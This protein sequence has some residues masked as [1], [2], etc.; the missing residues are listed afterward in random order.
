MSALPPYCRLI[1]RATA[2]CRPGLRR[3]PV[4]PRRRVG[5]AGRLGVRPPHGL[6]LAT[7]S[8]PRRLRITLT[9]KGVQ[10]DTRAQCHMAHSAISRV[11]SR[12]EWIGPPQSGY[13]VPGYRRSEDSG[14][15]LPT[16]DEM[17]ELR[18]GEEGHHRAGDG[19]RRRSQVCGRV[20]R[21]LR[22]GGVAASD[23]RAA[24]PVQGWPA[25]V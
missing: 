2:G 20:R 4:A 23:H 1:R 14:K 9:F 11:G 24:I 17:R 8:P 22:T 15:R 10:P 12:V 5:T 7:P 25:A 19:D 16:A 18:T 13:V 21:G 6:P 3:R